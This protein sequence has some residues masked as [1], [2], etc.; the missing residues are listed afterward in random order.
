MPQAD[1]QARFFVLTKVLDNW[2]DS[3]VPL[4]Y[5]KQESDKPLGSGM[6]QKKSR[7]C[8]LPAGEVFPGS[9]IAPFCEDYEIKSHAGPF[10]SVFW[11]VPVPGN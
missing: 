4:I 8:V 5:L 6:I 3:L 9:W 10:Y 11:S 7:K 2:I 1:Y